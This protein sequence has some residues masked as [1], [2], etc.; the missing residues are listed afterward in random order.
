MLREFQ[1]IIDWNGLTRFDQRSEHLRVRGSELPPSAVPFWAVIE[2]QAATQILK[3][4]LLGHR[5]R[6]LRLLEESAVS[7]GTA[8]QSLA[9]Q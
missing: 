4:L 7:I 6:A 3:E 9:E 1:G 5:Q 2:A 8:S